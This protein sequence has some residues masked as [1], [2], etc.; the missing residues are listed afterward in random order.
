VKKPLFLAG[1]LDAGN[2]LEAVNQVHPYC[3][4]VSSG[5]ET[6]GYKD[7]V[8]MEKFVDLVRSVR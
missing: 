7:H 8:K 2:V 5:V 3:V 6:D 1:G 4:D